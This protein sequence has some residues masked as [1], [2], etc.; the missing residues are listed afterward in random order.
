MSERSALKHLGVNVKVRDAMHPY[1]S[2]WLSHWMC[3]ST[4]T[5]G[6]DRKDDNSFSKQKTSQIPE[7]SRKGKR[8]AIDVGQSDPLDH[9]NAMKGRKRMLEAS[10]DACQSVAQVLTETTK[11]MKRSEM[12]T[13]SPIENLSLAV[14]VTAMDSLSLSKLSKPLFYGRNFSHLY[15][16]A[17]RAIFCNDPQDVGTAGP[18]ATLLDRSCKYLLQVENTTQNQQKEPDLDQEKKNVLISR[19]FQEKIAGSTS[20]SVLYGVNTGAASTGYSFRKDK[21][22]IHTFRF[23]DEKYNC[24]SFRAYLTDMEIDRRLISPDF[25]GPHVENKGGGSYILELVENDGRFHNLSSPMLLP[26]HNYNTG[27]PRLEESGHGQHESMRCLQDVETLRICTTVDSMEQTRALPKFSKTTEHVLMTKKTDVNLSSGGDD[28]V[29]SSTVHTD[30]NEKAFDGMLNQPA[31]FGCN[32]DQQKLQDLWDSSDREKEDGHAMSPCFVNRHNES[33]AETNS[34]FFDMYQPRNSFTGGSSP[35]SHK[36]AV[37]VASSSKAVEMEISTESLDVEN[38]LSQIKQQPD[39]L[40]CKPQLEIPP[41]PASCSR[42][43]KCLRSASDSQALGTNPSKA[44]EES[45]GENINQL[46]TRITSYRKTSSEP[47]TLGKHLG[48]GILG[49]TS[50]LPTNRE[51]SSGESVKDHQDT[52]ILSHFWIQRLCHKR[53]VVPETSRPSP[54]VMPELFSCK[55]ASDEECQ[56]KQFPSIA[57]MAMMGRAVINLSPCEF[58]KK[59]SFV[60]WST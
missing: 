51:A 8:L 59:G 19:S 17:D 43:V 28:M 13:G 39:N 52:N 30:L 5:I 44:R 9:R 2:L 20:A 47:T 33:S 50:I 18:V 25:R 4:T 14:K 27:L 41:A 38:F 7:S 58:R 26:C 16:R 53:E 32:M 54:Q 60:V 57:A 49:N 21:E 29:K 15:P 45:C 24:R 22:N 37:P 35:P 6:D 31:F 34:M 3:T 1:Q 46:F 42:W 23:K 48:K 36:N 56:K 11:T 55:V 10:S 12:P 40:N